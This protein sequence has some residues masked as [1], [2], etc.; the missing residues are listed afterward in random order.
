ML[1]SCNRGGGIIP[2]PHPPPATPPKKP[3]ETTRRDTR[4]APTTC[5]A[6]VQ[7]RAPQRL[8]E[9]VAN[10]TN[11]PLFTSEEVVELRAIWDA[12]LAPSAGLDWEL[13]NL[14]L[15]QLWKLWHL[16]LRIK[17]CRYGHVC[18]RGCQQVTA[19][20]YLCLGF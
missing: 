15:F 19:A 5:K 7:F 16:S 20:I 9:H 18:M 6:F 10:N 3:K 11:S 8:R 13:V 14:T 2:P 12:V 1:A 4:R 17:M